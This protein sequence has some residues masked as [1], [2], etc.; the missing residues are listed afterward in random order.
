M[1]LI[2]QPITK[3]KEFL[4]GLKLEKGILF[5]SCMLLLLSSPAYGQAKEKKGWGHAFWGCGFTTDGSD[6]EGFVHYGGGVETLLA[7]G[8]GVGLELGYLSW[9]GFTDGIGVFSPGVV[10]AFN[11]DRKTIPFV[12]GGYTLYFREGSVNG[13]FLGGGI[14]Y[15][16]GEDWGIRV[17][18]R[19]QIWT[20]DDGVHNL[21]ARFGVMFSWD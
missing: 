2:S 20:A 10:Y 5:L 13:A 9:S 15:L 7:R 21:E 4:S 11:T 1:R 6:S 18:G 12:T 14:N 19:D 3:I 8:L 16:I 17:E